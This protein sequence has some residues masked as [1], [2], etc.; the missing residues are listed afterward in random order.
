MQMNYIIWSAN[1][2]LKLLQEGE[3][4]AYWIRLSEIM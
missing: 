1:I 2:K 3:I 4:I